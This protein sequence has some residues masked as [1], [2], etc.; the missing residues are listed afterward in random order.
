MKTKLIIGN[1]NEFVTIKRTHWTPTSDQYSL[2]TLTEKGLQNL[3][4]AA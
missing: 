3:K 4:I 2:D 1:A